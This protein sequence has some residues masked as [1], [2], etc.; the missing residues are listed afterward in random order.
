MQSF[1][2]VEDAVMCGSG[3]CNHL[4]VGSMYSCEGL[5]NAAM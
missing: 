5:K 1:A 3:V 4:E 2:G